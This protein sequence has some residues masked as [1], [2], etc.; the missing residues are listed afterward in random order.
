MEALVAFGLA[1]NVLQFFS[2]SCKLLHVAKEYKDTAHGATTENLQLD[3]VCTSLSSLSTNIA[4][5]SGRLSARSQGRLV[6]EEKQL[7]SI[8]TSCKAECD[9]LLMLVGKLRRQQGDGKLKVVGKVLRSV[10]SQSQ[11]KDFEKRIERY[12]LQMSSILV[13]ILGWVIASFRVHY[14]QSLTFA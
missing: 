7:Q 4:T 5:S 1:S 11:V 12:Q 9:K 8:A 6:V 14:S 2:F 13:F 3:E 10:W